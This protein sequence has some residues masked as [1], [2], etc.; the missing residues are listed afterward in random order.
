MA[1]ETERTK[2]IVRLTRFFKVKEN[3][4]CYELNDEREILQDYAYENPAKENPGLMLKLLKQGLKGIDY[5]QYNGR[6]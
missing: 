1:E 4:Y 6:Y 3:G 2:H 5:F